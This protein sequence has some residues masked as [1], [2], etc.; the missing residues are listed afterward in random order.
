MNIFFIFSTCS[1]F[2]L[3]LMSERKIMSVHRAVMAIIFVICFWHT[4]DIFS[5]LQFCTAKVKSG[6]D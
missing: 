6:K 2:A 3:S 5:E 4:V 1:V